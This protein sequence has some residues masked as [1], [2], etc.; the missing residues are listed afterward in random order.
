M[1]KTLSLL[2]RKGKYVIMAKT[3]ATLEMVDMINLFIIV[4]D[5]ILF[6]KKRNEKK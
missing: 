1:V 3:N 4:A 2:I 6:D 5:K